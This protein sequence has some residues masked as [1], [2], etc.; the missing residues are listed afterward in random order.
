MNDSLL[1][2]I[3][4]LQFSLAAAPSNEQ[5]I[6]QEI[7]RL[8]DLV[9]NYDAPPKLKDGEQPSEDHMIL[10]LL[11]QVVNAVRKLELAPEKREGALRK[12]VDEHEE[13]LVKRQKDIVAELAREEKELKRYITSDDLHM[14]FESKTVSFPSPRMSC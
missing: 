5:F 12:E 3:H 13:R 9:P 4:S 11:S 2:R 1:L 14:G 7:A 6:G 8:R 10:S